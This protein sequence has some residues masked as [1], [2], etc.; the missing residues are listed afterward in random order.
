MCADDKGFHFYGAPSAK[1]NF[2]NPVQVSAPKRPG[3]GGGLDLNSVQPLNSANGGK[4]N[5]QQRAGASYGKK[6]GFDDD[7]DELEAEL[8]GVIGQDAKGNA[9]QQLDEESDWD[10]DYGL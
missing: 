5:F 4:N 9:V 10:D 1:P 3:I 8:N 7:L 2:N 6:I